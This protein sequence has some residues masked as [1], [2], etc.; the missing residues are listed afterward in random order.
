VL[1][2]ARAQ[3]RHINHSIGFEVAVAADKRVSSCGR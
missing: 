2:S 3:P 1:R